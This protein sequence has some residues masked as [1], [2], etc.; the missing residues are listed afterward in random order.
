MNKD[1]IHNINQEAKAIATQLNIQDRTERIAERQA[2]ISLKDHKENFANNP[3]CRLINPAKSEIGRISK[4]ILQRIN[5][6]V[7]NK[8][9]LNQWKNSSSV[10]D[11]FK[12]IPDKHLH[13]FTIFDI[14]SFYPSI[15]ED[16]LSKAI[17]FAKKHTKISNQ[18]INIIMHC[19]KSILL[20]NE[21]AWA[22]K[23]N[24]DM[25]D[26][27]IGSFDGA[28]VCELV[29]LFLLN[30]LA[31]KYGKNNIGLYR[32]DGLAIF[33]NTTGPQAERTRKEITRCFKEHGLKITIQSNLKSVDYLDVT[34]NLTNGL[35]QP[36]R[37]PNDEPLYINMKSNHPPT[38]IKQ[39]PA[40]I[41][42]RLSALSSNKET[43]DK[44]KPIY[45]KALR[46]SGFNESLHYC[47]KNTTAPT[48]RNRK[49]NTIWFNPPYSKN[50]QTNVA[51]TFLNLI[52]KHFPPNHNLHPIFNKNNVKVSYSCM[53]NMSSIIK[54]HNKKILN[55][56]TT[57][58]NG[59][60]CRQK[61]QCPLDNNCLTTSVIYK[62][63][64]T[65]D[66]DNTGK[67]YI[68]LTEGT[69]KQRY[70]QHNLTFRN[71]KYANRTELAKHIW[72]L[73][74]NKEN[75]KI[76]WSIISSASAYNN[77]SKRCNLCI[78]EKLHIIKADKA[79][80]LNKR[81]ELIS[82][83]RHENKYFLANIDL[84]LQ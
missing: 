22:K 43:F 62:A 25:F 35:F 48:K 51:K 82:K 7:R 17:H 79:R 11:W 44:A 14:E 13:T 32:D 69:F 3:T 72:K 76:N 34:L 53:P 54:N 52:K 58:K 10:I 8:T 64:V 65:T 29:G 15:P 23:D 66:K 24:D 55:N 4:Q 81:T 84:R 12:N 18:D 47:K 27:T 41:N 78:T 77:I 37:K 83:C 68:G 2:F 56:N 16:L 61:D 33:K 73:K 39:I 74:D 49:R 57:P 31:N 45:D 42:R 67:N 28:E 46:S 75:Y 20:H 60:N 71:R 38:V 40:A 50:V 30:D 26:V 36:Y 59:C 19:R 1:I 5:T 21:S 80:N 6:E 63:N 70:T 9:S